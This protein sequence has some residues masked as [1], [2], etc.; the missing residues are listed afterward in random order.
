MTERLI[1]TTYDGPVKTIQSKFDAKDIK[2][3]LVGYTL[4]P[5]NKL[6]TLKIGDDI[7]YMSKNA[8]RMGGRIKANNFPKYIVC[9]NV[10]KKVSWC[11]QLNDPT[12]K[13]WVKTSE[14][15][16]KIR[17]KDEKILKMFK[18]GKLVQKKNCN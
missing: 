18:D 6:K 17:N 1:K 7:R 5:A 10:I 15:R 13:I 2:E 16:Q 8:F 11:V 3:K 9:L 12:L 14:D 4:V